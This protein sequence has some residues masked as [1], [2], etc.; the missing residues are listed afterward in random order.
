MKKYSLPVKGMTCA[1][2]VNRVEKIV[3]KTGLASDVSVNLANETLTFNADD[4]NIDLSEIKA[5]VDDYGYELVL[6]EPKLN[7]QETSAK[8][9]EVDKDY[10][11]LKND[12]IFAIILTLPIFVI[13][14]FYDFS[15]FR[16]IF[17]VGRDYTNKILLIITTPVMFIS[18]KRFFVIF[19]Q[20]LKKFNAEMNSLV[21]IGS[22]T[23]YIY[24]TIATLFPAEINSASTVPHVYFE[25]AAVIVTLI[26]MGRLLEARAK[27][28][29][30][31][32][33]RELLKLKP[34]KA[35]IIKNGKQIVI[36]S[37]D[38]TTGDIV[39]IKP[40]DKIPAD[41]KVISGNSS[42]DESMLTGESIPVEKSENDKVYTGTINTN[43]SFQFKVT[44][45]E[46]DSFLSKIITYVNEAQGSKVPVQRLADKIAGVF[47]PVVVVTAIVTFVSWMITNSVLQTALINTVAVLIVACPCALGLATP[48]AIMVATGKGARNGILFRN[49]ESLEI[50]SSAKTVVFDKTGTI[51][52]G[53]PTVIDFYS[54]IEDKLKVFETAYSL[55]KHS[56]HP[57]ASAIIKY[58]EQN[59]VEK[60]LPTGNFENIS[61]VGLRAVINDIEYFIGKYD[62]SI[63]TSVD[64]N[65]LS[66]F[67][68]KNTRE[69]A[70]I[71]ILSEKETAIAAFAITDKLKDN[72]KATVKQLNK[73]NIKT[74]LLSGD[75]KESVKKIALEAGIKDF[76]AEVLPNQKAEKIAELQ[77]GNNKV[78]M[79]GDG[80]NDAPALAKADI[81]IAM[82]AGTDVAIETA[83]ITI[84]QNDISKVAEAVNLS[85][86]T[87]KAIKQNLFWA[88]IYN[89]IG[90]P[91]AALG[92]LNPM[93]AAL[94]MS[95][96]SVSV[97]TNSLRLR[98]R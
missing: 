30:T 21:A 91:L 16:D 96:S 97:I 19:W 32:A 8:T 94:A 41:G 73:L 27:K 84:L 89:T 45:A 14:M 42:V 48:T 4:D 67:I 51:T 3:N 10:L 88:F 65:N 46:K 70:T 6:E 2:C 95:L 15:F 36:N 87:L 1:A 68:E 35:T 50:L 69:G 83:D 81:G 52:E 11:K 60:S 86:L 75:K 31:D 63:I 80:I 90:I 25:T 58:C 93:I 57:L 71:V 33:V 66:G 7:K 34:S 38:I 23:A 54:A 44:T 77:S 59:G 39:I 20:N 13:S 17:P 74:V 72:V 26:L 61:G 85:R 56:G 28:K 29:T 12:F 22:G 55:E 82:G 53:T 78:I 37:A 24:S 43:G 5:I 47:T 9:P 49:G 62:E 64:G 76:Y 79:V 92:M 18:A 40:G 98:N